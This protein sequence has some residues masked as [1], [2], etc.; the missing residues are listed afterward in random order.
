[1]ALNK[2]FILFSAVLCKN[3]TDNKCFP[4]ECVR[5]R[6][7]L[8]SYGNL[9]FKSGDT[10]SL[11]HTLVLLICKEISY[12]GGNTAAYVFYGLKLFGR[13]RH[14]C[15]DVFGSSCHLACRGLPYKG[16]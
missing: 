6:L 2:A 9:H 1:M 3:T 5:E 4:C 16:N 11:Y 8:G 13:H 7:A 15:V 10:Q 14:Q 12:R